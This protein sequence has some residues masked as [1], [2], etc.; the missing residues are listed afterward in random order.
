MCYMKLRSR[1]LLKKILGLILP[2]GKKMGL[3]EWNIVL[4]ITAVYNNHI[5]E[6]GF[7]AFPGIIVPMKQKDDYLYN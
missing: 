5:R 4:N 2:T 7:S 1:V 3:G 6:E